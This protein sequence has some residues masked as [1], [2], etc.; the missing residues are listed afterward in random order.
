[1]VCALSLMLHYGVTRPETEPQISLSQIRT[2]SLLLNNVAV[3][4]FT[5]VK[6]SNTSCF[7]PLFIFNDV[8]LMIS[9]SA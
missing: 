9:D 5:E 6:N 2:D 7:C 4:T 8:T 1:M 3:V